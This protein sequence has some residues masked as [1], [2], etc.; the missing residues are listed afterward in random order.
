MTT[1]W[2][3]GT[4]EITV[5]YPLEYVKTQLQLQQQAS[6]MYAGNQ[7]YRN[8]FHCFQRTIS[9]RGLLGLYQGGSVWV[10]FAGPRSA[11][12]FATFQWLSKEAK[13]L[14]YDGSG[15]DTA[16]GFVAGVVEGILCQTPMQN[17][18]IKMVHDQSPLGPKRFS[19]LVHALQ[20]IHAEHG[21]GRGFFGG[22]VPAVAKGAITNCIRFLGYGLITRSMMRQQQSDAADMAGGT[23][24]SGAANAPLPAW[25]TMLAG[26]IAGAVSAVVSQ[27]IDTVK[28]NMMGLEGKRFN[29]TVGCTM[30]LVR[31]GGVLSLFQ[32]VGPRAARVFV[33]VGLQFTLFEAIGRQLD[34][35][36]NNTERS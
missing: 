3:A 9:E 24:G 13:L 4:I 28:A 34:A 1:G 22:F 21:I 7:R 17:I 36:L 27:P 18:A 12:R 11:V 23:V 10:A 32:G 14:G 31:A 25:K 19:G 30:Q 15:V 8:S 35:L 26:G 2:L 6:H 29:S 5:T 33:E 20:L 16:S